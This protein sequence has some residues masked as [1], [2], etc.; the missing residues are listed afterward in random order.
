MIEYS[1]RLSGDQNKLSVQLGSITKILKEADYWSRLESGDGF[2]RREHVEK[3]VEEKIYR[4]NMVEEKIQESIAKGV[5]M[6][7][8]EGMVTG[9]INGLAVYN[10]GDYAFGKPSRITCE[11]YMGTEGLVNIERRARMSGNIHDKGVLI[12]SGYIGSNYAQKVPLSLSASIG[13]EQ[14]YEMIDGDSASAAE[15]IVLFSS[16]S[17]VPVKQ[18]LAITGSVNQKGQIQP[19][20]GVNEKVEGFFE[21]CK[22]KGL[23]GEQ[24]VVIPFQNVKNLM[25]KKSVV[26]AV[27]AGKFHIYPVETIEQA[28]ETM[29]GKEAG[30]RGDSGKFKRGT[31]NYLVDK[32]LRE[33]AEDY[34]KF[35]RQ[36]PSRKAASE[37]SEK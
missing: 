26:E 3:A 15:L 35:G 24:G 36:Q 8:T 19:I 17:G 33:F 22:A 7:D 4:S 30:K 32:K 34:R 37:N 11:T 5:I 18:S 10:M 6:V 27:K 2:T 12:L 21:V 31:I 28:T 16:L 25:L 13:F 9:Q 29:T 14:T 20:G 1:S 23:T